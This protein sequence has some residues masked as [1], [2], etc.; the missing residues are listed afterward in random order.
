MKGWR[1]Q[2]LGWFVLI[3]LVTLAVYYLVERF[4]HKRAGEA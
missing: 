4:R 3:L 1:I 2:P